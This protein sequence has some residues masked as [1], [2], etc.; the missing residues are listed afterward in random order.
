MGN[1]DLND[2]ETPIL[3]VDDSLQYSQVL[4]K[5]L[6][7]GFGYSN[8]TAV[9]TL[10]EAED[11]IKSEPEKFKLFFVDYN[12]PNGQTGGTFLQSLKHKKIL[13]EAIAFL[14]T[15][16]PTIDNMQ[17]A[18]RA[19]ALGVVAKPFDRTELEKQLEKAKRAVLQR[20]VECF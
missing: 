9:G 4:S 14:I 11:L 7:Y 6:R 8:V 3:I 20:S 15:A 18:I 12:L 5:L 16:D 17:E 19:G 1:T 13:E 2:S 10:E